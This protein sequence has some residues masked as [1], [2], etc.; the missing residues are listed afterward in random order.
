MSEGVGLH[1]RASGDGRVYQAGGDQYIEE[2]H[3][4]HHSGP[5]AFA[6]LLLPP[7]PAPA[8]TVSAGRTLA[9]DSVRVPL[10]G[11]APNV[12]RGRQDLRVRLR[13]AVDG[14]GRDIHVVHGM[15]GTGKTALA[16]TLFMDTLSTGA[17]IGFWVNASDHLSL[18]AGM[19]AVAGDRG[20][21][22]SE[23]AA[24]ASG[25]RAAADLVWHC[26]ER[27]AESWL[28]V[29]DNADDPSVLARGGWLRSSG[30][31]VVLVTS[32]HATSPLW[33]G[34]HVTRHRLD[35]LPLAD[36]A[37]VLCDLAPEAGSQEAAREVAQRLGCLPLALTLAGSHMA[38]QILESWSMED[39]AGK[40]ADEPVTLVDRGA[41]DTTPGNSRQ[42][43]GRTWQ[44]SLEAL[45]AQGNPQSATLLNL[46][47]FW[48][49]D[50]LPLSTLLPIA[51]GDLAPFG[52]DMPADRLETALRGLLDHSL[53]EIVQA[54]GARCLRTHGVLLGSV[55]AG[56]PESVRVP[57][58]ETAT[59]LLRAALPGADA[60]PAQAREALVLLAPHASALLRASAT[61]DTAHL[62]ASLAHQLYEAG[63]WTGALHFTGSVLDV[64]ER[65]LGVDAPAVLTVSY[66]RALALHRAGRF[67]ES[68]DLHRKV[69]TTRERILGP[70]DP[71]TLRSCFGLHQP[72]DLLDRD[73][74]AEH[75]LRRAVQGQ[76]RVLGPTDPETLMTRTF[77]LELL[78]QL[79]KQDEFEA[80]AHAVIA[81][82]ER[83]LPV[84][85][86]TTINARHLYSYGL[87]T[88]G[89]YAEALEPARRTLADR[90]RLQGRDDALTISALVNLARVLHG[91]GETREAVSLMREVV[92]D[93]ERLLGADHPFTA[94]ARGRLAAW[95]ERASEG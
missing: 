74:E 21:G 73:E 69:L 46:L 52:A 59:S 3:H 33:R 34:P 87:Q 92:T 89:R 53:S 23:V 35:V 4:H 72:L 47:S 61:R 54:P 80:E 41:M 90:T 84:D 24:A 85:H 56:M 86:L 11:R 82:C 65:H 57:L 20:A 94:Y 36:A 26:L 63:D 38:H 75:Y 12:L 39:Y 19:L 93:R 70:D 55:A 45:A 50:P 48:S 83:S 1:G 37:Q 9:P 29:L 71:D 76:Q 60:A 31:G 78:P 43:V 44:I 25:Q 62:V 28:L 2:H 32:R 95:S 77:L 18:R 10:V 51:R 17:R 66:V 49:A 64:V 42:L 81:D 40:L 68:R 67:T 8:P 30:R 13:R 88:T 14:P 16:Y 7:E 5:V 6:G 27:S 58:S 91:L 79:G 15:G 22:S